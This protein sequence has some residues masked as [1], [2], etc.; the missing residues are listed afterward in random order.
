MIEI[1][2]SAVQIQICQCSLPK[3]PSYCGTLCFSYLSASY[4]TYTFSSLSLSLCRSYLSHWSDVFPVRWS[5]PADSDIWCSQWLSQE[6]PIGGLTHE[7]ACPC[8]LK[9]AESDT[10]RWQRDPLC[11][12]ESSAQYNCIYRGSRAHECIVPTFK[13]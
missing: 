2:T 10:G 13:G 6:Q 1:K 12:S 9:Q 7:A 11:S 5:D 8:T 4:V 3:R